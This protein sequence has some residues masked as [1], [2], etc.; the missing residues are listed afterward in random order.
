MVFKRHDWKKVNYGGEITGE[1]TLK[2]NGRKID[3]FI[4]NDNEGYKR[5][6]SIMKKYGFNSEDNKNKN[7]TEEE[8]EI[9]WFKSDEG[10]KWD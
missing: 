10:F 7:K 3:H 8:K 4:F 5:I 2:E 9:D 1:I 6:I